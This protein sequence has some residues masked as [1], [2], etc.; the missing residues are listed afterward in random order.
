MLDE[1]LHLNWNKSSAKKYELIA[2]LKVKIF[3]FSSVHKT[4]LTLTFYDLNGEI[5]LNKT[6]FTT[7]F[8]LIQITI[9]QSINKLQ[10]YKITI[11]NSLNQFT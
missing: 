10:N 9:L 7:L 3:S 11:N 8:S 6:N 5:L 4:L 1:E 2:F